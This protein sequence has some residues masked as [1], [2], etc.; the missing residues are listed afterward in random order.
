M[1]LALYLLC[2]SLL[3]LPC[4]AQAER[5]ERILAL[6]PH[7]C[8]ML[9]AIGAGSQ[10]VGAVSYCDY[11]EQARLLP[12]VGSYQG[13]SVEA[14][15]RLRPDAAIVLNRHIKGVLQLER[16]GVNVIVSNPENI[17]GV[18]RDMLMLG[19]VTG[20][21]QQARGLV[22]RQRRRLQ[23]VRSKVQPHVR[24]FYELWP[25]PMLTAGGLSFIN[26]L[27]HEAGGENIFAGIQMDTPHVNIESVIRGKPD[28]IVI[29]LEKR[30]L[31]EREEFWKQWLGDQKVQ[32]AAIDPD[33]LHRP[34][35]RLINGLEQ[36]QRALQRVG[37]V[38]GRPQ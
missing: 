30:R 2:A 25:D 14:A 37:S 33:I 32:F 5:F 26:A 15:L 23:A 18:F 3:L 10:V 38:S 31:E 9:Y 16:M 28:V 6:S 1:R 7:A 36:L 19:Q 4:G 8:E 13:V 34:G 24:V 17:E 29:P 12:R 21:E 22:E 27:I 20:H 11:P 35:P